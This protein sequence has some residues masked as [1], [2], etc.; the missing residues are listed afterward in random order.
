M[1]TSCAI[2]SVYSIL[3]EPEAMIPI[4]DE[5]RDGICIINDVV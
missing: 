3:I 5:A 1:T 4:V 2:Q